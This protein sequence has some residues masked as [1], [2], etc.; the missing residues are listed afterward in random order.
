MWI[1]VVLDNLPDYFSLSPDFLK[2]D[3]NLAEGLVASMKVHYDFISESEEKSL[4]NEIE[5]YMKQLR[6]EFDHWDNVSLESHLKIFTY[7]RFL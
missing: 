7:N 5:P 3:R 1:F 4:L 6:Y 2:I